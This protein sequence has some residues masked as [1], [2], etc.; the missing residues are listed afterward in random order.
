M[1][2]VRLL[3]LKAH[4]NLE[5]SASERILITSFMLGLHDKQLS[6][7]FEVV[8]VQTAAETKRLV[9]KGEAVRRHQK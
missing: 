3:V 6:A 9:A 8:K 1:H 5:H 7:S 2:R 4:P